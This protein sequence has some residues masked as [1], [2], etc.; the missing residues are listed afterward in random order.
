[1]ETY[2][3]HG[4][5]VYVMPDGGNFNSCSLCNKDWDKG[6]KRRDKSTIGYNDLL[7]GE[8]CSADTILWLAENGVIIVECPEHAQDNFMEDYFSIKHR[9]PEIGTP[10]CYHKKAGWGNYMSILFKVKGD[11]DFLRF[12]SSLN[13]RNTN[14][15]NVKKISCNDFIWQLFNLG[16]DLGRN[17]NVDEILENLCD[18]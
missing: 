14:E 3:E 2:C 4:M 12:N 16:F 7:S 13:V 15:D 10:F 9:D 18:I 1:M 17:H 6:K 5:V 11:E 8:Y